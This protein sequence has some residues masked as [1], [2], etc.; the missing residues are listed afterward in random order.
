MCDIKRPGRDV[1]IIASGYMV[2]HAMMAAVNLATQGIEME[3]LDVCTISPLDED[4]IGQSAKKTGRVVVVAEPCRS[5]GPTGEWGM[6][7]ME[8]AFEYL[9]AP[10]VRVAGRNSPIPFADSI[11]EGVWPS[12]YD[13]EEAVKQVMKY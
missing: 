4:T 12:V 7:V 1:S 5:Y 3:V 6:V 8:R 13:V 11:E 9:H 10:I 2:W